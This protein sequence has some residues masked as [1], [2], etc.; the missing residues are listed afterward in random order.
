MV[1]ATFIAVRSSVDHLT[2]RAGEDRVDAVKGGFEVIIA[3]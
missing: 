3:W 1:G 2:A